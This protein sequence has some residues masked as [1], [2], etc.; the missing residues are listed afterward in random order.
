MR[1]IG[2]FWLPLVI[3]VVWQVASA[4]WS[5][6]FFS[7]PSAIWQ[8]AIRDMS[9]PWIADVVAPTVL[10]TL[11]GYAGG[12]IFGLVAGTLIGAH[13]I[14]MSVLGPVAVFIRSVPSAATIPVILAVF[15]LGNVSL[16][17]AVGVTVGIQVLLVTMLGVA[18]TEGHF[19]DSAELM[20]LNFVE[21]LVLV[22]LPAAM[23]DVLVAL[24]ASIQTALLVAIT[25]E[26]LAGGPGIGRYVSEALGLFQLP[27]LWVAVFVVGVIGVLLHEVFFLLEK[28]LAP[29]FFHQKG[30]GHEGK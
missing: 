2:V 3:L 15:G 24:Q 21:K 9:L 26:I 16:Y 14:S 18:R 20:R 6:P 25:V 10:L 1:I 5:N 12:V 23:S 11:G 8:S 30:L 13:P 29:W 27:S 17:V 22:R 4:R 7:S 28:R 19:R